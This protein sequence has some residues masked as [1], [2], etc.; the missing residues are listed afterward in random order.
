MDVLEDEHARV[1]RPQLPDERG[2]D[3]VGH[4][5]AGDDLFELAA[6]LLGDGEQRSQRAR[7]E[8][9]VAVSRQHAGPVAETLP[10]TREQRRLADA[11][12][13]ADKHETAWRASGDGP[14]RGFQ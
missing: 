9:W 3:L 11:S 6:C 14:E 1:S 8:Q 12:I 7:R 13:A 4:D 2:H 5:A 10:K